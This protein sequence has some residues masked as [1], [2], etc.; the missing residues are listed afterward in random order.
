MPKRRKVIAVFD[1]DTDSEEEYDQ[2]QEESEYEES[3]LEDNEEKN[4]LAA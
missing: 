2:L 3:E 4:Q 1:I